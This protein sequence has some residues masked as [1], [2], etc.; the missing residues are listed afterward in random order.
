MKEIQFMLGSS[1]LLWVSPILPSHMLIQNLC[2]AMLKI[3]WQNLGTVNLQTEEFGNWPHKFINLCNERH[4]SCNMVPLL[5]IFGTFGILIWNFPFL[6]NN[7]VLCSLHV[8]GPLLT[9]ALSY[10]HSKSGLALWWHLLRRIKVAP[11]CIPLLNRHLWEMTPQR[12]LLPLVFLILLELRIIF[13]WIWFI[14]IWSPFLFS[15]KFGKGG[16]G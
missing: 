4:A 15:L 3:W 9:L 11:F 8:V 14:S 16:V 13:I 12:R 5:P 6:S 1:C 2:F 10:S 7:M